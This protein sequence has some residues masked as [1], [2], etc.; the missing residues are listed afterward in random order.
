MG[1]VKITRKIIKYG[2]C[3]LAVMFILIVTN[4]FLKESVMTINLS[5]EKISQVEIVN[6]RTGQHN[7][8]T[9]EAFIND[10]SS[11]LNGLTLVKKGKANHS[12][13]GYLI[14]LKLFEI[15][16]VDS[17]LVYNIV[18]L[19]S[20]RILIDEYEYLFNS[21]DLLRLLC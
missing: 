5:G 18:I 16:G 2:L 20:Q 7:F 17:K 10:L 8:Y 3:I 9:D 6:G 19:D 15:C 13:K 12:K 14:D 11:C 21:N 4:F 1:G